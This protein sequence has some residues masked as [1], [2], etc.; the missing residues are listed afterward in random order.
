MYLICGKMG[1]GK[2]TIFD[3][4]T[5]A[6]YGKASGSSRNP[7]MFRSKYASSDVDTMV[8]LDF[9]YNG[10]IY[11]IRRNPQ[12]E[13][14]SKRGENMVPVTANAELF[15][16]NGYKVEK[17]T[18]VT[19]YVKKLIG[20]DKEQFTRIA[21]LAQGEF[22]KLLLADSADRQKVFRQLFKTEYFL[23]G[24]FCR[25]C[26]SAFSLGSRMFS[27]MATMAAGTMPE[28]PKIS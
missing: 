28:P 11:K 6:L 27:R 9:E 13:R 10:E 5:F 26:Y 25:I 23:H 18:E 22:M 14:K 4:I 17:T 20:L 16:P 3:A 19:N 2:T 24:D 7:D 21:M 1:S 8:E 15:C 12:Y